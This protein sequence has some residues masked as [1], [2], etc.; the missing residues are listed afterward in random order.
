[1]FHNSTWEDTIHEFSKRRKNSNKSNKIIISIIINETTI[2]IEN[3]S[4][5][6]LILSQIAT[7]IY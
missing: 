7:T 1:M 3:K 6:K 4:S 2:Y 5:C